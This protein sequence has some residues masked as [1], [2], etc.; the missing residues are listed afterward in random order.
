MSSGEILG[1]SFFTCPGKNIVTL[2]DMVGGKKVDLYN[3]ICGNT[4]RK[5]LTIRFP[6]YDS[7]I[8]LVHFQNAGINK[9]FKLLVK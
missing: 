4:E 5:N 1:L 7:G 2:Y 3:C 6:E 8:Y 9:T